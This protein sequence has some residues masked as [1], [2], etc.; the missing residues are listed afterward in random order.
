MQA[1]ERVVVI[2]GDA[3]KWYSQAVFVINPSAPADKIPID[4]VAEAEKIIHSY[5]VRKHKSLDSLHDY[6]DYCA[7]P[8]ILVVPGKPAVKARKGFWRDI[9]LYVLMAAACI[10]MTAIFAFGLLG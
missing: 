5:M 2:K 1:N 8:A 9:V 4:F 3:T 6:M 7:P 10:A